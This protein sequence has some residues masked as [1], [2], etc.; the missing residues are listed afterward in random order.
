[1]WS[2][3]IVSSSIGVLGT[4]TLAGGAGAGVGMAKGI[5][6]VGPK[7]CGGCVCPRM[8]RGILASPLGAFG[9]A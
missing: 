7:L 3:A 4:S 6:D 1:M 9:L 8:T 2:G 5:W